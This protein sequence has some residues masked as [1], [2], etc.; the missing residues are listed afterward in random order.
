MSWFT[1][2]RDAVES[3]VGA[4]AVALGAP[5]ALVTA[6]QSRGASGIPATPLP[7]NGS[8]VGVG[9]NMPNPQPVK[10]VFSDSKFMDM[11]NANYYV[12]GAVALVA[13]FIWKKA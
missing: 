12:I 11:P 4:G 7:Q 5:P 13:L 2:I 8:P 10:G 9:W 6:V 1:Q 3:S